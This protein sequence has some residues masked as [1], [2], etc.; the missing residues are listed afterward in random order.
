[1]PMPGLPALEVFLAVARHGSFRKAA[2]ERGVSTSALSH[3]MRGLE[4]T[5]GVRLFHR[6]N[7]SI[8]LTEA[9]EHLLARIGPAI[10]ELSAAIEQVGA[11]RGRPAGTLR[12]NVPRNAAELVIKPIMGRFMQTYPEIR[13]EIV[14]QDG[15]I[16]IVAEGF[17]AGIRAGQDLG[18]DMIS[19]PLGPA[20]R[21][22]VVGSPSYFAGRK[23]PVVPDDLRA[24]ACLARRYPN[25]G[26]YKWAFA[27]G[28]ETV[29]LAV[30]GQL[31]VDDRSLII[32][33][34]LDG[35]GLAHIHEAFVM[36]HVACGDLVRVLED[37][38]PAKP[39]FF[40]YYPG[41]RQVPAPLRAFIGMIREDSL[42]P[43]G[44]SV[45]AE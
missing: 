17:D 10:G 1:M 27:R 32:A 20:L 16:D 43:H 35:V 11:F 4:Q 12:L 39:G 22:A 40:L 23:A 8:R 41:R 45:S 29:E 6:T 3:V 42:P 15:F 26:F 34:A 21:F 33:A 9:G 2:S 38:C 44:Q 28:D 13:L 7:R 14:T 30:R 5:I 25:G 19:V 36:N 31:V 37:W 24:H 18:L